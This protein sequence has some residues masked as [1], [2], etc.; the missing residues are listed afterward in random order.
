MIIFN[1]TALESNYV[2]DRTWE[3]TNLQRA[4]AIKTTSESEG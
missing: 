2:M 3:A 1:K 4:K